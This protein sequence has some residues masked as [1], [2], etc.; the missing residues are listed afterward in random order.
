MKAAYD[1]RK[2]LIGEINL[3]KEKYAKCPKGWVGVECEIKL[4]KDLALDFN[5]RKEQI[6]LNTL[7]IMSNKDT[8][9]DKNFDI[10]F[11]NDKIA[12]YTKN[13]EPIKTKTDSDGKFAMTLPKGDYVI[14]ANGSRQAL[15]ENYLWILRTNK[16]GTIRLS[17]DSMFNQ[18]CE[19]CLFS[20]NEIDK[21]NNNKKALNTFIDGNGRSMIN[22]IRN[23]GTGINSLF[24]S[25]MCGELFNP[26]VFEWAECVKMDHR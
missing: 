24:W 13:I 22:S 26:K 16:S 7:T 20:K 25:Y 1:E 17:N 5:V 9:L 15:G 21:L 10:L 2:H 23:N 11:L 3:A 8:T 14:V 18:G 6:R 12:T 19:D 4:P